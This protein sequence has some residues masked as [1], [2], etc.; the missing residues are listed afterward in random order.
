[1]FVG[2]RF[3]AESSAHNGVCSWSNALKHQAPLQHTALSSLPRCCQ[4]DSCKLSHLHMDLTTVTQTHSTPM[5]T[6]K[7][8]KPGENT[9]T[10]ILLV[11]LPLNHML[12]R[13]HRDFMNNTIRGQACSLSVINCQEQASSRLPPDTF[14][15]GVNGKYMQAEHMSIGNVIQLQRNGSYLMSADRLPTARASQNAVRC[16]QTD[17]QRQR[18]GGGGW[19]LTGCQQ[20]FI[21]ATRQGGGTL[22]CSPTSCGRL[23]CLRCLSAIACS[24]SCTPDSHHA[25]GLGVTLG[26]DT[27]ISMFQENSPPFFGN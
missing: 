16:C 21:R 18:G 11:P 4:C 9:N 27:A 6:I 10:F 5:Y 1:M 3:L 7:W 23:G 24:T 14:L 26:S 22:P 2:F 19:G 15:E 12:F 8:T 13:Q 17:C 20:S 25:W